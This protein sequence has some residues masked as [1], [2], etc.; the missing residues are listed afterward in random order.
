MKPVTSAWPPDWRDPSAYPAP[1]SRP[2]GVNWAW[3][4][5]RRNPKYLSDLKRLKE[6]QN[7]VEELWRN[8]LKAGISG[9]RKRRPDT[10]P[11]SLRTAESEVTRLIEAM[12]AEYG[13]CDGPMPLCPSES[14]ISTELVF[15]V[16]SML[17]Y[18]SHD[19]L[20]R[21][22][23]AVKIDLTLPL[24]PQLQQAKKILM[25]EKKSLDIGDVRQQERLFPEYLRL[26]DAEKAGATQDEMSKVIYPH[27]KNNHPDFSGRDRV[28][29]ALRAAR[30]IRDG[31]YKSFVLP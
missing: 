22:E 13:L 18:L 29:K 16:H 11:P 15:E 26:L 19:K 20:K 21:H 1:K 8:T 17:F 4:F 14:I 5:L 2:S 7:K 12:R 6:Q 24:D 30:L 27:I 28:K 3:E 9:I 10:W 31:G 25:F 23:R